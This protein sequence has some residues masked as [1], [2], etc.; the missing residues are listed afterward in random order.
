MQKLQK[1]DEVIVTAGRSKG[2]RGRILNILVGNDGRRKVI[3]EQANMV[4]KHVKPN[5]Q[6]GEPGGI[7]EQEAPLDISNVEIW[8]ASTSKADRVGIRVEKSESG[9]IKRQRIFKS[10]QEAID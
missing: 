4:K 9:K 8:N 5:P 10:T 6:A 1:N 2:A 7:K 3:V